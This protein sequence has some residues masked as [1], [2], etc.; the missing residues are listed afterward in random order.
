MNRMVFLMG[1][2]HHLGCFH[3]RCHQPR[4]TY[5]PLPSLNK[6]LVINFPETRFR[7]HLPSLI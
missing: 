3:Q 4:P 7:D 5:R 6:T 2:S 1:S